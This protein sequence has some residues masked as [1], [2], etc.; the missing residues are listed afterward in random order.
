MDKVSDGVCDAV[1]G[2]G[3]GDVDGWYG[4]RMSAA[5]C[6]WSE[7]KAADTLASSPAIGCDE[8][9]VRVYCVPGSG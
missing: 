2:V 1:C 3:M 9:R 7:F 5:Q 8:K 6:L 4:Q